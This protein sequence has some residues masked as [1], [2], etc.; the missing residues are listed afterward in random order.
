MSFNLLKLALIQ[1]DSMSKLKLVSI[2]NG[3]FKI[4][5]CS[6]ETSN[7]NK[8]NNSST[9][10]VCHALCKEKDHIKKVMDET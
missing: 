8:C 9:R 7:S 6:I 2:Y 3:S 5:L 10:G 1:C 4:R